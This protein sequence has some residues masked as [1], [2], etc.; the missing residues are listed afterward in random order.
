MSWM[1]ELG[2]ESNMILSSRVRIARNLENYPFPFL[3][4]NEQAEKVKREVYDAI[5]GSNTILSREFMF[6]DIKKLNNIDR[7]AL[8]EKHLAS[9]LLIENFQKSAL[10]VKDDETISIM[11]NEEDHLRI[12]CILP[13]FQLEKAWDLAS[14]IDDL[15]EERL[16]YAYDEK[17]GYLT[18]CPTNLGTGI[19]A[20]VMLHLPGL[21]MNGQMNSIIEAV[22]KV[23]LT[24]RGLYGEGSEAS[25][26]IFQISNQVTLGQTEE[27]IINN[28][29][30]V[31]RQIMEKE[32][33]ARTFYTKSR[34]I[35]LEDR[36]MRSFGILTNCRI[37]SSEE[38]MKL[39]SDVRLG[40]DLGILKDM[41]ILKLNEI[42]IYMRPANLQK[43]AG[44][45]LQPFERDVKR[46]EFVRTKLKKV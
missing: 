42:M 33:A 24:V 19:R 28:L 12:Q 20:S 1:D 22:S 41:S 17:L 32:K 8:V 11:V 36:I 10:L 2:P 46:A 14:K 9:P 35:Q 5:I 18:C 23:G 44:K 40:V 34:L 39:L 6:I 21:V 45:E 26:N 13:G 38:C 29:K 15:L 16:N 31:T 4:T 7:E 27:E 30:V 37:L 3:I 43:I 25:G